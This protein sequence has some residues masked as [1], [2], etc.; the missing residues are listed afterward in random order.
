MVDGGSNPATPSGTKRHIGADRDTGLPRELVNRALVVGL[1]LAGGGI[2]VLLFAGTF[3]SRLRTTEVTGLMSFCAGLA[4]VLAAFGSRAGGQWRSWSV[5][6]AAALTIVLLEAILP[7]IGPV[8]SKKGRIGADLNKVAAL[9]IIDDN[10]PLYNYLDRSANSFQFI[11]LEDSFKTH[12]VTVQI[13]PKESGKYKEYFELIGDGDYITKKYVRKEF[14]VPIFWTL[15]YKSRTIL[16][17]SNKGDVIFKEFDSEHIPD[18]VHPAEPKDKQSFIAPIFNDRA[19]AQSTKIVAALSDSIEVQVQRLKSDEPLVRKDARET[20]V[21]SGPNATAPILEAWR[22]SP[23]D[24]RLKL[25]AVVV[26]NNILR[27]NP[28]ARSKIAEK[29]HYDDFRLFE[30]AMSD[31]DKTVSTQATEFQYSI[32]DKRIVDYSLDAIKANTSETSVYNNLLVLDNV[33]KE[34]A[35]AISEDDRKRIR[36]V[37]ESVPER[38]EKARDLANSIKVKSI[39]GLER[40]SSPLSDILNR[41]PKDKPGEKP[42]ER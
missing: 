37:M 39:R 27:N 32:K 5:V 18:C 2:V 33:L 13:Y 11:L 24:Y 30:S 20:L 19:L 15:N 14:D 9:E 23:E 25:G 6:G 29:L 22:Q 8:S 12:C 34:I 3:S 40:Q 17:P 16:D 4:I 38:Y 36:E 1:L 28:D 21:A 31:N 41:R 7:Y 10:N 26:I 42:E 35:S